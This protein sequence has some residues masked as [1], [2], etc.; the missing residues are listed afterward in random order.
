MKATELIKHLEEL[1]KTEGNDVEVFMSA[2]GYYCSERQEEFY[3][4]EKYSYTFSDWNKEAKT[5]SF[6]TNTFWSIG[7][8]SQN[9]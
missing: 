7:H 3:A 8:S 6:V 4:P 5:A 9:Y 1:I 2:S